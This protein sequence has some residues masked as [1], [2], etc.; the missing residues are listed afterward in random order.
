VVEVIA[1]YARFGDRFAHAEFGAVRL[2]SV[3]VPVA[4][5]QG[6][7]DYRGRRVR[8]RLGVL[9]VGLHTKRAEPDLGDGRPV[10]QLDERN[11]RCRWVHLL[12]LTRSQC[13]RAAAARPSGPAGLRLWAAYR[14]IGCPLSAPPLRPGHVVDRSQ[15]C[16]SEFWVAP[17]AFLMVGVLGCLPAAPQ[18]T[19]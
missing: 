11:G 12:L 13:I 9:T 10:V 16:R 15:D 2:G 3:D 8:V 7:G 5:L 17:S 4:R 1:G 19:P 6:H 14:V 18:L